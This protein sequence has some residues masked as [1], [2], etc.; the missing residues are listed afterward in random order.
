MGERRDRREREKAMKH[1]E[2]DR[3]EKEKVVAQKRR[4]M[5]EVEYGCEGGWSR[6]KLDI[7]FF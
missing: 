5:N 3:R 7:F 2:E 4:K 6:R 1:D